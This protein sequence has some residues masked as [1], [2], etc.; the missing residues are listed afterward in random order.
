VYHLV[1]DRSINLGDITLAARS[2]KCPRHAMGELSQRL[3]A[4]I[5]Q[6]DGPS[7]N[8]LDIM[9]SKILGGLE[10]WA[11]ARSL[12]SQ[13]KP[14][15]LIFCAGDGAGVPV[16]VLYG[17]KRERPKIAIFI[18]NMDRPRSR[19]GLKLF[20]VAN[21]VDLFVTCA[22]SQADFLRHYL[23]L[24]ES[25]IFVIPDQTDTNFFKPGPASLNKKRPLIVS[26]GLEKRDYRTLAAATWDLDVDVKISGFSPDA[27]ALAQAFPDPMPNNMSR[28]FYEWTELVQ[29]YRDADLVVVSLLDNRYA[30]G[31]QVLMEAMACRRPVVITRTHGLMEY[32]APPGIV[33]VVNV[34]D[35]VDLRGAIIDLLNN[36][37][38]AE[39]QAQRGYEWVFKH[40]SN[41]Q[42]I[43][44]LAQQLMLVSGQT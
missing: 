38:A 7:A 1:L 22:K 3:G 20:D 14:D 24:P 6:P 30:A 19:L 34:A 32:L 17:A 37:Q 36:P 4:V 23:R 33:K 13:L 44:A 42:Y 28:R 16:A 43:E 35:P 39:A 26:V 9:R 18:H 21:K 27:T 15:D 5:H 10:H 2:G 29:L 41:E 8:P 11:L 25:R 12:S 40:H 31:V